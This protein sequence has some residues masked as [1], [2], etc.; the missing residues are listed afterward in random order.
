MDG[1]IFNSGTK[2][3]SGVCIFHILYDFIFIFNKKLFTAYIFYSC[4]PMMCIAVPVYIINLGYFLF[5]C[6][7]MK[8]WIPF[9]T[10]N[11]I[12]YKFQ[13]T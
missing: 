7:W 13:N 9:Y 10:P 4:F 5:Y 2:Y 11:E 1:N 8:K 6:L 12:N 3:M